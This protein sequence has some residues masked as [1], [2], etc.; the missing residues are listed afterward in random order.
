MKKYMKGINH[1]QSTLY[2]IL[3]SFGL[4]SGV[5]LLF[6]PSKKVLI[7]VGILSFIALYIL[8]IV[9]SKT[10]KKKVVIANL[11]KAIPLILKLSESFF[12]PNYKFRANVFMQDKDKKLRIKHQLNM[13]G[14]DDQSIVLAENVGVTGSVWHSKSQ[15]FCD[16]KLSKSEGAG[17]W[18]I[19]KEEMIKVDPHMTWIISTPILDEDNNVFA[20]LNFDSTEDI[21]YNF[22]DDIKKRARQLTCALAAIL[23]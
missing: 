5:N 15:Q 21:D 18:G 19:P 10:A 1:I 14:H 3:S 11:K 17:A 13:D 9:F 16:V 2:A 8:Y 22:I 23:P 6:H 7:S 4:L 12:P 20:V